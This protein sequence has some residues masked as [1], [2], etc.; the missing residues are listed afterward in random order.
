M[1]LEIR[2]PI[3]DITNF[4]LKSALLD[5]HNMTYHFYKDWHQEKKF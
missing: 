5:I 4:I 1:E 3:S 2:I